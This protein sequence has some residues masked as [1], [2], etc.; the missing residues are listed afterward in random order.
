[1]VFLCSTLPDSTLHEKRSAKV[2]G[3]ADP[4]GAPIVK[5]EREYASSGHQ[6]R[7]GRE[8]TSVPH[9]RQV[10]NGPDAQMGISPIAKGEREY[11]RS[12]HQSRKGRE[13]TS[14]DA[15]MGIC[16]GAD[17]RADVRHDHAAA[18]ACDAVHLSL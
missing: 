4:T 9:M 5:G 13:N 14:P 1:M 7:K 18:P 2:K 10:P 6:S 3:V 8:N 16:T 17:S 11:T 12:G 15:Q